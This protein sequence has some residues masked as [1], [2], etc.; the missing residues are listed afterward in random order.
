ML[1]ER[2]IQE[3]LAIVGP[4]INDPEEW[5]QLALACADQAG[6]SVKAQAKIQEEL[7]RSP[8]RG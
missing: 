3:I 7:E 6:A 2:A 1:T 8:R 4:E 5:V